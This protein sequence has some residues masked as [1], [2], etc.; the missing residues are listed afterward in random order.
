MDLFTYVQGAKAGLSMVPNHGMNKTEIEEWA[1]AEYF[2][3][4]PDA[5]RNQSLNTHNS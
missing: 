4:Y 3:H 1:T 5:D 2:R